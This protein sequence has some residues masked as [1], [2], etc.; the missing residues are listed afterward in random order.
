MVARELLELNYS[1]T[2]YLAIFAN[3]LLVY[4]SFRNQNREIRNY[5]WIISGEAAMEA[6]CAI[7][8]LLLKTVVNEEIFD[9]SFL[10]YVKIV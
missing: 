6:V 4:L 10:V 5:R 7:L 9:F 3:S 2:I 1:T 8:F